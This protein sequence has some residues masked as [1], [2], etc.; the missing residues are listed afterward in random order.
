MIIFKL[1]SEDRASR[2]AYLVHLLDLK[3]LD[4][5]NRFSG[6]VS[7]DFIVKYWNGIPTDDDI[8]AIY[9][10]VDN[11][12]VG[13]AHIAYINKCTDAEIG[14]SIEKS[15]QSKGFGFKLFQYCVDRCRNV[16]NI[17]KIW[18]YCVPDNISVKKIVQKCGLKIELDDNTAASAKLTGFDFESAN[19][20]YSHDIIGYWYGMRQAIKQVTFNV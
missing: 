14:F 11:C 12:V 4:R 5:K 8:V 13:Y 10:T 16:K 18:T 19:R 7:T 20:L 1:L 3:D 6:S 15:F 17:K 9:S 2:A